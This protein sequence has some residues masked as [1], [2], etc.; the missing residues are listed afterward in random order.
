MNN[1]IYINELEE[2]KN[3]IDDIIP[4]EDHLFFIYEEN[5]LEFI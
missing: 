3:I 2:L 5:T 1:I 4:E